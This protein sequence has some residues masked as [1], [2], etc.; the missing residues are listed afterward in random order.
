MT[1]ALAELER[2]GER[3]LHGD[4]LIEH[5]AD[6]ERH[7][8]RGDQAIGLVVTGEGQALGGGCGACHVGRVPA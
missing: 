7:R 5:E 2:A 6:E 8:V 4:L 1:E 3:L